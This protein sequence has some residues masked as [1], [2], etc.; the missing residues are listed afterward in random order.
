MLINKKYNGTTIICEYDSTNLKKGEY[1]TTTKKLKLTFKND[2]V[3]EYDDVPLE[4]FSAMNLAEST[5]KFFIK[6]IKA[7]FKFNKI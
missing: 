1:D 6:N 3:Y 2:G 7:T 5:G 4:T